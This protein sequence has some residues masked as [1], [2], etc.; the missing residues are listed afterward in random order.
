[1]NKRKKSRFGVFLVVGLL[2]YFV[3]IFIGQEKV[4][5]EKNL[6][7]KDIQEKTREEQKINENLKKQKEIV[8][9]DEYVEK[10]A[11]EKLGMVKD[12]ERVFVDTN[13]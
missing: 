1:M 4:L 7:M 13:K 12:G 11:R 2:V 10:A 8:N 6:E 5:Y 9:T 3:W